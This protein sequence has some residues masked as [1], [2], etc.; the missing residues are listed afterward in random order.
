MARKPPK[1]KSLAEVNPELAKQWHKTKNGDLTPFDFTSGSGVKIWWKCDKGDDHEWEQRIVSR[2]H[3]AKCSVCCSRTIVK[4]NC[5]AT[6]HPEIAKQWH[7]TKNGDLTSFDIGAGYTKKVWWKCDKVD[8]HKWETTPEHR[9]FGT[10]CPSCAEYGFNR[11]EDALFYIRKINLDNGKQALKFGI[12]N[13][14]DGDRVK[15][16][17]RHVKGSVITIL[18][19]EFSG[20]IA[21]SIEN[22]C[23]KYFGRKGFL[24]KEEFPNGFTE[25]IKYS[26]ENLIKIKSIVDEVLTEKA[27][28]KN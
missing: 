20:E 22:L 2:K 28:K 7:P 10:G 5:I 8:D 4:S 1:G 26:E 3:G 27:E 25:T 15:Q 23:K 21:L 13:N 18:R 24:T 14:K 11:S 17:K 16:Q 6:T 12:T 19:E 9:K